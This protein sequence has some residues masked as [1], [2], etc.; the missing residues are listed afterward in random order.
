MTSSMALIVAGRVEDLRI[1]QRRR[2]RARARA[3]FHADRCR[4]TCTASPPYG[5]GTIDPLA[6][7]P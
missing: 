4:R 3:T 1:V 6:M 2:P 5:R 7:G